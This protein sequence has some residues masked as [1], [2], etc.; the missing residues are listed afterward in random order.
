MTPHDQPPV[1][2]VTLRNTR[3]G[4]GKV[5]RRR[6]LRSRPAV[7]PGV[8]S[9]NA[10][11]TPLDETCPACGLHAGYDPTLDRYSPTPNPSGDVLA[12]TVDLLAPQE[13]A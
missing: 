5:L 6:G 10:R 13:S 7:T 12:E 1:L 9:R 2:R 11:N 3:N 8:T 4:A